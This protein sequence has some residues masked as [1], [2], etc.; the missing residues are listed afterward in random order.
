V[1]SRN[2]TSQDPIV[3]LTWDKSGYFKLTLILGLAF[4]LGFLPHFGYAYPVHLDEWIHLSCSNEIIKESTAVGLSDPFSGGSPVFQQLVEVGFHVFWAIFHQISGIGWLTIFKYFPTVIFMITVLA[5]YIFTRK[6]GFGWE[7][8]LLTCFIPTTVGVLGPGFLVPVALGLCFIALSIFVTFNFHQWWS[9]LV[10]LIFSFFLLSIHAATSIALIFFIVPYTILNI[11]S[12]PK[13]SLGVALSLVTP[14]LVSLLGFPGI[15][16]ILLLPTIKTL[17]EPHP[18]GAFI[19]LPRL[20]STLGYP[21]TVLCLLGAAFLMIKTDKNNHS[22]V[23]GLVALLALFAIF[24]NF[25]YGIWMMYGRSYQYIWFMMSIIAGAGLMGIRHF[26]PPDR[27]GR[28]PTA[29]FIR[30]HTGTILF[31]VVIILVFFTS[32]S[33]RQNIRYYNM[34]EERDYQAFVWIKENVDSDYQK[35]ILD[36]WKGSAFTAIS[37]KYVYT[38]IGDRVKD[39]DLAA[40]KFLDAGCRDTNFL[41]ENGI[42]IVYTTQECDNQDLVEVAKNVYLLR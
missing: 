39:S 20:I 25:S 8:A 3:M 37:G 36:P 22:F 19:D 11:R 12:D 35:A 24:H 18:T 4:Y 34:I 42:S 31:L 40:Y 41:K 9:Y 26:H 29:G 5:V 13:H 17:L 16:N 21:V 6:Q 23:W 38:W 15:R 33:A 10:L 1:I 7:A 14:F 2:K 28:R 27:L 32:V 30:D